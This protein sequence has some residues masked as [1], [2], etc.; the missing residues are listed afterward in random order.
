MIYDLVYGWSVADLFPERE[1]WAWL[2]VKKR[3]WAWIKR[4]WNLDGCAVETD[5]VLK[6]KEGYFL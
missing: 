4:E 1:W 5:D 2:S 3:D 6:R